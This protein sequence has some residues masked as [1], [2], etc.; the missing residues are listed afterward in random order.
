MS[1]VINLSVVTCTPSVNG[2]VILK[3]QNKTEA[4][5]VETAFG[6]KTAS[7]QTTYYMKVDK[8]IAVGFKAD[9]DIDAFEVV[10]RPYTIEDENSEDNG[11]TINCKWLHIKKA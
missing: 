1:N 4:K 6:T 8:P 11:K 2:G 9:L 10:E 5:A 7:K 3:L